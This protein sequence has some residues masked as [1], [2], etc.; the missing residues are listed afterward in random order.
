MRN[1]NII[2]NDFNSKQLK[3]LLQLEVKIPFDSEVRT[4]DEVFRQLE[5]KKTLIFDKDIRGRIGYNPVNMLKLI[6]FCQMEM[7][8]S[9]R[10][11][12]KAARNDIRI[13]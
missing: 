2:H 3:L 8:Q 5:I 11:M 4:F 6:I 12:E 7:I 1:N 9:L 13:I 10:D